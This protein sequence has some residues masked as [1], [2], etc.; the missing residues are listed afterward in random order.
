MWACF[1][2]CVWGARVLLP[3]GPLRP[4]PTLG[5]GLRG[6]WVPLAAPWVHFGRGPTLAWAQVGLGPA[7]ASAPSDRKLNSIEMLEASQRLNKNI[8]DTLDDLNH[9][10]REVGFVMPFF[11][12]LFYTT[13]WC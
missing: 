3:T 2:F 12:T 10:P 11:P 8:T 5:L 1:A 13:S 6:P 7:Q 4:W 9:G